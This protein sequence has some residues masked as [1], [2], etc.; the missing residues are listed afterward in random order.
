[1]VKYLQ[2]L[3]DWI[4]LW[5]IYLMPSKTDDTMQL[6]LL[7]ARRWYR[8]QMIWVEY[9]VGNAGG[10]QNVAVSHGQPQRTCDT[11]QNSCMCNIALRKM[12][13]R[14]LG[15]DNLHAFILSVKWGSSNA[16]VGH[17]SDPLYFHWLRLEIVSSEYQ[18]RLKS[19]WTQL[20]T[21]S[22]NFMEVRWRSLFRSTSLGKRFTSYNVPPTPR[23]RAADRWSLR[24]FLPRNSLFMIGKAQKSYG[25]RSELNSVFDSEK[26]DRWNPIRTSAI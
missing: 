19:S 22:R 2:A 6:P 16:H 18:G 4:F 25:A 10:M 15:R 13:G 3:F 7:D 12:P 24:N 1:M 14:Y 17:H 5:D 21:P 20:I 23:K 26:V 8:T 9:K 11:T